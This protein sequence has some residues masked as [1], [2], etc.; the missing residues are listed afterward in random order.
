M[1]M[2]IHKLIY[3]IVLLILSNLT[4]VANKVQVF[5]KKKIVPSWP[6]FH[7]FKKIEVNVFQAFPYWFNQHAWV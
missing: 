1:R 3:L 6:K 5:L 7:K 4:N 2:Y